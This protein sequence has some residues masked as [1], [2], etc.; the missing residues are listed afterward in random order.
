M[1]IC[2]ECHAEVEESFN[3]CWNC[4]YSFEERRKLKP[5]DF[6]LVCPEC[7]S[8][9]Q[10]SVKVCPRCFHRLDEMPNQAEA[11]RSGERSFVCI[12]CGVP[13]KYIGNVRFHPGIPDSAAVDPFSLNAYPDSL[14]VYHC[15]N[16]GKVESL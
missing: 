12:R 6:M 8:E 3:V 5:D 13:M 1:K 14:E 2:P 10:A 11:P 15:S 7:Q 4:Q 9:V 16:C